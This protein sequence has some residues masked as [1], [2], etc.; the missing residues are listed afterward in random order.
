MT[1]L[2]R[3]LG[4]EVEDLDVLRLDLLDRFLLLL[5]PLGDLHLDVLGD[6]GLVARTDVRRELERLDFGLPLLFGGVEE[7][8]T[9]REESLR[10]AALLLS[11]VFVRVRRADLCLRVVRVAPES[12]N[13]RVLRLR[14]RLTRARIPEEVDTAEGGVGLGLDV[15]GDLS[16]TPI[17]PVSVPFALSQSPFSA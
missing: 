8:F 16:M 4:L 15:G 10:D 13:L 1:P 11:V 9:D 5:V 2:R 7:R 17:D 6:G 3:S 12:A 14:E